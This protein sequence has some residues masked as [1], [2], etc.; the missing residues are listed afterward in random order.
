MSPHQDL[1]FSG[2]GL[3]ALL[4]QKQENALKRA[5]LNERNVEADN[6][7]ETMG[8]DEFITRFR[9]TKDTVHYLVK[10]SSQA[11]PGNS[12]HDAEFIASQLS[13]NSW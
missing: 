1:E 11:I 5:L 7:L 8:D 3:E 2:P 9:F 13:G 10:V 12:S 4:E 6:P